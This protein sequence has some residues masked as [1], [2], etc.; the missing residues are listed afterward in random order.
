MAKALGGL[1][2]GQ[3]AVALLHTQ[4]HALR[5]EVRD[6]L[7]PVEHGAVVHQRAADFVLTSESRRRTFA[8]QRHEKRH[9]AAAGGRLQA[10][11]QVL[12]L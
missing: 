5:D 12:Q 9:E 7:W 8:T 3:E 10:V 1:T 6:D 4:I 11:R 2:D